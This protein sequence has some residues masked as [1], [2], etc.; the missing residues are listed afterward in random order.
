MAAP[1]A[2][3]SQLLRAMSVEPSAPVKTGTRIR[4]FRSQPYSVSVLALEKI[5]VSGPGATPS[6]S[7]FAPTAYP[8][9]LMWE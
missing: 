1:A 9:M 4:T 6:E 8:W 3:C 7:P 2:K 5:A